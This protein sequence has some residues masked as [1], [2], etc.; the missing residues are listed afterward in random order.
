MDHISSE[1]QLLDAV[2]R[3]MEFLRG[4]LGNEGRLNHPR[5]NKRYKIN[6][7]D[8]TYFLTW[9]EVRHLVLHLAIKFT[10]IVGE[11]EEEEDE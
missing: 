2:N 11:I 4:F 6:I 1:K 5:K 7:G 3:D 10:N 8:R 9:Y